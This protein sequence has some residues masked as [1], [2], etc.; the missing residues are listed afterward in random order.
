MSNIQLYE[1]IINK[2]L[3][4][5]LNKLE[6]LKGVHKDKLD[7][8]SSGSIFAAYIQTVL[9]SG[10]RHYKKPEHLSFQIDVVNQVIE[11]LGGILKD[12]E[13]S[14][15]Q[16]MEDHLLRGITEKLLSK[17]RFKELMPV[18]SVARSS[19]FTGGDHEPPV[20]MELKREIASADRIDLLVSFI[21]H[22]GLRL[23]YEDLVEHTK[24]K[25]LR[26]ITTSYM[27]ATDFKAVQLLAQLP[28]TEVRIS[29]DINRTRLHAKAY[30]FHRESGFSTAYIG[31]SN[32]SKAALSEGTEWNLKVS[33]Y[34]SVELIQKYRITF[35][36]YWNI[37]EFQSFDPKKLEDVKRLKVALEEE[38]NKQDADSP[39]YYFDIIPYAYQ[40]TILDRLQIEREVYGSY[41]N[42]IVAATGTGKT[43][44]AAFDFKQFYKEKPGAKVLFLA[45]REEILKQSLSAFRGVLRDA[46][47]GELWVGGYQPQD[48][49]HV[50]ASIQTLNS[51]G[52]YLKFEPEHFDYIVLDES[53]HGAAGSYRKV[54]EHFTP[55]ILLG[56]TAT[57]ER[58]DGVDILADFN[59]RIAYE[60]RLREAIDRNLLCP[61]HY[62]GVSDETDLSQ[63]KW[64]SGHYDLAELGIKFIG[65]EQRNNGILK[66]IDQYVISTVKMKAL[67]FCVT[68]DHARYM[69]Q[70]FNARGIPAVHL[71]AD[72]SK[73][74][75]QKVQGKLLKG[76]IKVI[77]VV[78][79]YNEGVDIPEI[80]V[81][82]FLRPTESAT[83][84]IQQLGR[85]LRLHPDKEVLT[86]LDFIGQA[87]MQYDYR[88]KFQSLIGRTRGSLV[89]EINEGFTTLPNNCHI[90]L[91]RLAKERILKNVESA[92]INRRK[93]QQLMTDFRMNNVLECTFLN[94]L[95]RYDLEP[96]EVYRFTTFSELVNQPYVM[97][98]RSP[99]ASI[100]SLKG[101]LVR[102]AK[103]NAVELL[104]FIQNYFNGPFELVRERDIRLATQFYYTLFNTEWHGTIQEFMLG[105]Y[106]FTHE[107]IEEIQDV[108]SYNLEQIDHLPKQVAIEADIPLE[109]HASYSTLHV[110]AAVGENSINSVKAFR[111]GAKY[112]S[113]HNLDVFFVTL[114][115]SEKHY[116]EST[117]YEDYAINE[118]LFHWQSQSRT[119]DISP[120]GQR[121]IT[122]R[123]NG[124]RV[125]LFVREERSDAYGNTEVY[126]LLGLAKY[127]SH[128]GSAPISITYKLDE[129]MP[130]EILKTSNQIVKIV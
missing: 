88:M 25:I 116:K 26:V 89:T 55:R 115:K 43:V 95:K 1:S 62:F 112:F 109:L 16:I 129:K 80:N 37:G 73:E 90:Q 123:E 111:E 9:E 79:L 91:E 59:N 47:F 104:Q 128:Q 126:R 83:V 32:L 108:V 69:S 13:L 105:V 22:S 21:K 4:E 38:L 50:F 100:K 92:Y 14:Q 127:V 33:E 51:S 113:G 85:G 94:F 74:E 98:S 36:T 103:L 101:A 35:E 77:F 56:L 48:Y 93:L 71:D 6:V 82:M 2:T 67:G 78:D 86:V 41:R 119:S 68:K 10:L 61:F 75:R 96:L 102:L 114:N 23:I 124:S 72:S 17:D 49:Q 118:E 60:I 110:F 46:N 8:V 12:K 15:F 117:R 107:M 54:L 81:V 99:L 57:P 120:T 44:V 5:T 45:H 30:Y 29:Y 11:H 3:E 31:S 66:A 28:N 58:M 97:D 7:P 87:H 34:S 121:Y 18:S 24:T 19:L 70:V 40:Q 53:H 125:L 42:L 64:Q 52:Q 122:M 65:N 27:G 106:E 130:M 39:Q 76:E 63:I 84:F 20:Y